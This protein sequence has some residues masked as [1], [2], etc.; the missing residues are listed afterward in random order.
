[1]VVFGNIIIIILCLN[2]YNIKLKT[3]APNTKHKNEIFF[4]L[5]NYSYSSFRVSVCHAWLT[6][7]ELITTDLIHHYT[8]SQPWKSRLG[9]F[10]AVKTFLNTHI[11]FKLF[12]MNICNDFIMWGGGGGVSCLSVKMRVHVKSCR[13]E[14]IL[15]RTVASAFHEV[16]IV[17]F[18]MSQNPFMVQ[19]CSAKYKI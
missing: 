8:A 9:I 11:Y 3:C 17:L 6:Y 10:I 15:V 14:L 19:I 13:A 2:F 18:Q 5:G 4:C 12:E 16:Q 7:H 1:M